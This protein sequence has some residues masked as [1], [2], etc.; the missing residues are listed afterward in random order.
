MSFG[1]SVGDV[2]AGINVLIQVFEALDDAKGGKA[3][4]SELA[5]E[6]SSFQNALD[7]IR[8]YAL[9]S[10]MEQAVGNCQQCIDTFVNRMKKFKNIDKDYGGSRWSPDKFMKNVRAVEWAMCKKSE[11]DDFRKA[12]LFHTA[13]IL[14]L[15]ISALR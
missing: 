3:A 9:Q 8:K 12:V 10:S 7:G 13:A 4:H 6:L 1:W 11:V 2:I 14:S 5:R 15:Q